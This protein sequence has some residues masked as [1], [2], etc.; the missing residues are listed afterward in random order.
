MSIHSFPLF[1]FNTQNCIEKGKQIQQKT[2]FVE[3]QKA[4][5]QH[6]FFF[7]RNKTSNRRGY[8][9]FS[10][11]SWH[12]KQ[13]RI[14]KSPGEKKGKQT[15]MALKHNFSFLPS[16][17]K[18]G[19]QIHIFFLGMKVISFNEEEEEG[20]LACVRIS[21]ERKNP[22]KS[23]TLTQSKNFFPLF[24]FS[25]FHPPFFFGIFKGWSCCCTHLSWKTQGD[26]RDGSA[27]AVFSYG[28]KRNA[29]KRKL[30]YHI[31]SLNSLLRH[32]AG[33]NIAS[34]SNWIFRLKF[35][36]KDQKRF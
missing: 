14:V 36:E 9:I 23:Q 15:P 31:S 1:L 10:F 5:I 7:H 19:T 20:K 13:K 8:K 11:Y 33:N 17:F 4:Y 29:W 24:S 12:T 22:E 27:D 32:C 6:N 28:E 35:P 26:G 34:C 21:S 30:M 25:S 2:R 3:Q 16:S 18:C